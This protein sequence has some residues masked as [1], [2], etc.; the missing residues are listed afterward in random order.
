MKYMGNSPKNKEKIK[1]KKNNISIKDSYVIVTKEKGKIFKK[2]ILEFYDIIFNL[3]SLRNVISI[4]WNFISNENGKDFI[5]SHYSNIKLVIG[6]LGNIN[7]GKSFLLKKLTDEYLEKE[8]NTIGLS[9]KITKDNYI[10]IDTTGSASPIYGENGN[11]ND[12]LRDKLYTE[13]F[14]QTY[15]IKY[16]DI[17][18]LIVGFLT[19]S[20]QK[21]I[22]RIYS[23][24]KK[25]NKSKDKN[26]LIIHNL[27]TFETKEK[28]EN[29]IQE[30]LLNSATFKIEESTYDSFGKKWKYYYDKDDRSIKH[31]FLA[32]DNTEAGNFYN[33]NTF[34]FIT[35]INKN[36]QHD[37]KLNFIETV[38]EH[39]ENIGKEMFEIN[40]GNKFQLLEVQNVI[41]DKRENIFY[42]N[43][44][45]NKI[46]LKY[47]GDKNIYL[48]D[49]FTIQ[50]GG[51][52]FIKEEYRPS[53]ECYHDGKELVI[54]IDC[55][56]EELKFKA[57]KIKINNYEYN[58]Q[59]E[60]EKQNIEN[61]KNNI[62]YIKKRKND[63]CFFF[64]TF[65]NQKLYIENL[66]KEE[67]INGIQ[68]FIFSLRAINE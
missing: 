37:Y 61:K 41:I 65:K 5:N 27:Q 28:V 23:N 10:F 25:L 8:V 17:P 19:F 66:Q 4:G 35:F 36:F 68:Y 12:I 44:I 52:S 2:Y 3:D 30:I 45:K 64:I 59:I 29:Y 18:I 55:C 63:S 60:G 47:E 15:I 62:K 48:K 56:G 11:Y 24:Y 67:I 42:N 58:I 13:E 14:I 31:L 32:K 51:Y 20:E 34:D 53:Y 46:V 7:V 54:K 40:P 6:L 43:L 16:S 22:K 26:L 57:Q 49:L 21:L 39:F 33:S 1:T 50:Y 38:K 9:I